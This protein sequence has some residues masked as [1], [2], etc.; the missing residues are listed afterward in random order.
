MEVC[1]QDTWIYNI[2]W[3]LKIIW[4]SFYNVFIDKDWNF[5]P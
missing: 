5:M 4:T 1:E 3:L 2:V